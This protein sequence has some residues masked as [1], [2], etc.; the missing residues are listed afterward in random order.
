MPSVFTEGFV[1]GSWYFSSVGVERFEL[2]ISCSQSR[3]LFDLST[4]YY[5]R[6]VIGETN[7]YDFLVYDS[8]I[9]ASF[10]YL[11]TMVGKS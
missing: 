4:E 6:Y 10:T 1:R 7:V 2:L 8:P 11:E 9:L 5:V 3:S